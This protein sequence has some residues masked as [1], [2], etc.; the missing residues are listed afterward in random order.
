MGRNCATRRAGDSRGGQCSAADRGG[1]RRAG[2]RRLLPARAQSCQPR[3][4][5]ND[6]PER[7]GGA[8]GGREPHPQ[9]LRTTLTHR[10]RDYPLPRVPRRSPTPHGGSAPR[11]RCVLGAINAFFYVVNAAPSR[12][13]AVAPS[14]R[15]RRWPVWTASGWPSRSNIFGFKVR[16]VNED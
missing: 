12:N 10:A 7:S 4:M 13:I 11:T 5:Q 2:C 3:Q 16:K 6:T 9:F 1:C 8:T 15:R 14:I